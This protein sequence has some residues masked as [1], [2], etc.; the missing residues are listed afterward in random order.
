MKLKIIMQNDIAVCVIFRQ[1]GQRK[2]LSKKLVWLSVTDLRNAI[3]KSW[4]KISFHEHFKVDVDNLSVHSCSIRKAS[5]HIK[6]LRTPLPARCPLTIR[7]KLRIFK[8]SVELTVSTGVSSTRI[9]PFVLWTLEYGG[10]TSWLASSSWLVSSSWLDSA[11]F[12]VWTLGKTG[13]F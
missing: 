6:S 10:K 13:V 12:N 5:L 9:C 8:L 1:V 2:I 7:S 11:S 3:N 4:K